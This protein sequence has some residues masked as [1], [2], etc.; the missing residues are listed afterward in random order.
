MKISTMTERIQALAMVGAGKSLKE[1]EE[2]VGIRQAALSKMVARA[3][4]RGYELGNKILDEHVAD[5]GATTPLKRKADEHDDDNDLPS[6]SPGPRKHAR[7][8][9]QDIM[10]TPGKKL[11]RRG[12]TKTNVAV[13]NS[14]AVGSVEEVIKIKPDPEEDDEVG[15]DY[16]G[17]YAM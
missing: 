5:G 16:E 2:I 3:K 8:L 10:A 12:A 6:P 17:L 13:G 1:V 7:K 11:G 4:T 14:K 15:D 9:P